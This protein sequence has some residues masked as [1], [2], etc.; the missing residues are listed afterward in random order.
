M[1]GCVFWII[2]SGGHEGR[3]YLDIVYADELLVCWS[4]IIFSYQE[5]VVG[6]ELSCHTAS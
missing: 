4:G 5:G 1:A 6:L 2:A 3:V